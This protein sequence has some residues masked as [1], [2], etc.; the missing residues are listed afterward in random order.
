M[1]VSQIVP[2]VCTLVLIIC[3][4]DAIF[5]SVQSNFKGEHNVTVYDKKA[6]FINNKCK[7]YIKLK[8]KSLHP[9]FQK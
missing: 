3:Q 9:Y 6:T 1:S 8:P 5:S 4:G 2:K 7:S